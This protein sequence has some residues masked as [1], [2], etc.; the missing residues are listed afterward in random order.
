MKDYLKKFP[1]SFLELKNIRSLAVIAML[2]ALRVV[3]G[4]FANGTLALFGNAVKLSGAF[5]PI[6]VAGAMFGPFPAAL[7]G[8]LGDVISFIFAP[9]GTYFPGFTLCGLLTGLIYGFALYKTDV[10][11]PRVIIAWAI[12]TLLVETFLTAYWLYLLYSAGSGKAYSAWLLSRVI[13]QAV[14]C[15]PEIMLIFGAG[16]LVNLLQK[17]LL[18]T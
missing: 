8:A 10:T 3:L 12:N 15:A 6:A 7:V 14:K 17:H 1:D 13:S 5:L 2:L 9:T 16:R 4:I 18:K 11:L